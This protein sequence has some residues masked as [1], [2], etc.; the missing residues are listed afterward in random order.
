M[1][2]LGEVHFPDAIVARALV[3]LIEGRS[4]RKVNVQLAEE[5]DEDVPARET[6]R[7]WEQAYTE[8]LRED[9]GDR[10]ERLIALAD[11]AIAHT[12]VTVLAEEHP[13]K[14]L[15]S[16]NAVQGTL[17]DKRDRQTGSATINL[18]IKL[19]TEAREHREALDAIEADYR[20]LPEPT[21]SAPTDE[22]AAL[23]TQGTT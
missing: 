20:V 8:T 16:V 1:R 19:M 12:L 15:M 13:A 18:T 10:I 22:P 23:P 5:F 4:L 11:D 2:S 3:L 9:E 14:Y 7:R 21:N 17:R 6:L